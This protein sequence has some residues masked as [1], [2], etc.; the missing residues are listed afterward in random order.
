[1]KQNLKRLNTTKKRLERIE[2]IVETKTKLRKT[3]YHYVVAFT[4]EEAEEQMVEIRKVFKADDE[5]VY[6]VWGKKMSV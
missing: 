4:P 2:A 5:I 6:V 1:M 3:P